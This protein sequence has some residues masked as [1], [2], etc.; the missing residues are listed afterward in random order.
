MAPVVGHRW[1]VSEMPWDVSRCWESETAWEVTEVPTEEDPRRHAHSEAALRTHLCSEA[2]LHRHAQS[3]MAPRS[4]VQSSG[5]RQS[6]ATSSS[7]CCEQVY[8][9]MMSRKSNRVARTLQ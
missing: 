2:P 9:G 7:H 4:Y 5:W 3:Y 1:T 8:K 6:M